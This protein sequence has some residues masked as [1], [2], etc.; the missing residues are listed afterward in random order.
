MS[1]ELAGAAS[2]PA[3]AP[4]ATPSAPVPVSAERAA[5]EAGDFG[6]F[7]RAHVAKREGKTVPAPAPAAAA[8]PA[9]PAATD[10]EAPV[11]AE[12]GERPV[13]KR[14]QAINDYER[15]IA[16]QGQRIQELER[17]MARPSPDAG[18]PPSNGQPSTPT[19][20]PPTAQES[21]K[22]RVAR[23]LAMPDAPK[24]DDFD[25]YPEFNAAQT[26][27]LQDKLQG[28]QAAVRGRQQQQEQ[29]LHAMAARDQSFRDRLTEAKTA[30]PSFV[31]GLSD[32]AK[33]LGGIDHALRSGRAPG[34]VNI[35]GELVYD[36]PH[37]VAFLRHISADPQALAALVTPPAHLA[38]VP[39][40]W[41]T[42]AHIDHLVTE[43]RRLEGRL[44]YE[45]ALAA[46][47]GAAGET[48]S[49]SSSVSS[50]P[51]PPPTLGKAGRSTDPV[52][53]ALARNDFEAFDQAEIAKRTARRAGRAG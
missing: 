7:D 47:D 26:L 48:P 37:A 43:F 36:S 21:Q 53:S 19:Q 33:Q 8:A 50:A 31:T 2:A 20:T 25:T 18:P 10:G 24:V 35:I 14:Q 17:R 34:P 30:D 42:K 15:R 39:P 28:E 4:A 44:A 51:P 52:R 1:D 45:E 41:R 27:F 11:S 40:Q 16:E 38:Q 32:E 6:A 9:P 13:S 29:R 3:P 12:P 23:Y 46:R 49:P 22:Q 5:A